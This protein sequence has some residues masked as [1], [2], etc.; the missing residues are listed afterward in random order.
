MPLLLALI[1]VAVLQ[2]YQDN[3]LHVPV[4]SFWKDH[5]L[6]ENVIVLRAYTLSPLPK[7]WFSDNGIQIH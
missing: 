2:D 6:S 4:A 7:H 3:H 5:E 1:K